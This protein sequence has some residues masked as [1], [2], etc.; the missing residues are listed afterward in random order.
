MKLAKSR[1]RA[2][3]AGDVIRVVAPGAGFRNEELLAGVTYLE[4]QGFEVRYDRTIFER[5]R[6]LAGTD[7]RRARELMAAIDDPEASAIFA[8]RGGYGSQRLLPR[9]DPARLAAHP[10]ILLGF[11]DITV[12]LQWAGQ[13]ADV[14]SFHGPLVTQM[15]AMAPRTER[16]LWAALSGG[17]PWTLDAPEAE[18]WREGRARGPLWGGSLK[19]LTNLVGTPWQP[20]LRGAVLLLEDVG[21]KPYQVDRMLSH[22]VL[23]GVTSAL[24]GLVFGPFVGGGAPEEYQTIVLEAFEGFRGPILGNFPIGHGEINLTVPLGVPVEIDAGARQMR[25]LEAPVQ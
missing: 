10:K 11:S 20:D 16:A 4:G 18:A 1:P 2:L 9:L 3:K 14:V 15:A 5:V 23:S 22:L 12:L 8:A 19:L 17:A 6:Y 7:E 21:E 24:E 25:V 13:Q